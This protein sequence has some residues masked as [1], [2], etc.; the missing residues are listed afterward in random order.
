MAVVGGPL[1]VL[2]VVLLPRTWWYLRPVA[3]VFRWELPYAAAVMWFVVKWL[4]WGTGLV[5]AW[6]MLVLSW[7][8]WAARIA[9]RIF[10]GV[11]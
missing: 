9:F 11:D 3:R 4:C 7:L 6:L 8:I 10:W 2:F 5:L 1:S